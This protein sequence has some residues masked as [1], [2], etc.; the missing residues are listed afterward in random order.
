[1]ALITN[2]STLCDAVKDRANR[3]DMTNADAEGFIQQGENRLNRLLRLREMEEI[4]SVT[5]DALGVGSL[6]ADFLEMRAVYDANGDLVEFANPEWIIT[7]NTDRPKAYAL[8]GGDL[9][10]APAA[11]ETLSLLYYAKIPALTSSNTTNWLL[12]AHPDLYLYATLRAYAVW[13]DED[14]EIGKW[15]GAMN[16]TIG[17]IVLAGEAH[18]ASGPTR[19]P[20]DF[21]YGGYRW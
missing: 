21:L 14:E 12:T 20:R 2:F 17:E 19:M 4:A 6:P 7:A 15:D 1:M 5:T 3:T 18:R 16:R 10:L 9:R 11:A 8:M 13:R